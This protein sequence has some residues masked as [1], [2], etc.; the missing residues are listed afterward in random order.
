MT[1]FP[2]PAHTPERL[3]RGLVYAGTFPLIYIYIG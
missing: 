3:G 2:K 1:V